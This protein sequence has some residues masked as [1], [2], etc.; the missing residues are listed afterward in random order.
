VIAVFTP[1]RLH[2]NRD[3]KLY[4]SN[5][6]LLIDLVKYDDN[7]VSVQQQQKMLMQQRKQLQGPKPNEIPVN[8]TICTS[9]FLINQKHFHFGS[10]T[11]GKT[12]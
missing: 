8:A 11:I 4:K 7:N 5:E 12:V 10:V 1:K 9:R 2:P 3:G 6:A